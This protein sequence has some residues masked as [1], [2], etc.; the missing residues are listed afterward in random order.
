MTRN[1]QRALDHAMAIEVREGQRAYFQ[2]NRTLT[3]IAAA[4]GLSVSTVAGVFSALSPNSDYKGNLRSAKTVCLGYVRGL[5]IEACTVSTYNHNREKAW[6]I[7]E[8]AHFYSVFK[9]LKVRNFWR[10]LTEPDHPEAITIDGHMAN[11][12]IWEPR[13]MTDASL[14]KRM[15]AKLA[16]EFSK[17]ATSADLLPSQLQAILWLTWKRINNIKSS[18]N[19]LQGVLFPDD[20]RCGIYIPYDSIKTYNLD[21]R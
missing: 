7:L 8:G 19:P 11:I 21:E 4:T 3:E 20:N 17:V 14:S 2:Y 6:R 5:P 1:I 16:R 13:R 18:Y 9:G 15:Y 12:Y 10:N